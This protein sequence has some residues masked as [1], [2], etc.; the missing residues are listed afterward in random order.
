M[1]VR[2][3]EVKFW[4]RYASVYWP[5]PILPTLTGWPAASQMFQGL[6]SCGMT[7]GVKML[8]L[9]IQTSVG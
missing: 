7:C 1:E 5:A 2:K 8:N 3:Q 6:P 9:V 4:A